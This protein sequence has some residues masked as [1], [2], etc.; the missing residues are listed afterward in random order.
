MQCPFLIFSVRRDFMDYKIIGGSLPVAVCKLRRGEDVLC[1]SGAMSW[2]DG[3]IRMETEGGGLG[4]MFGRAFS[5]ESMFIN[6]YIAERDGEIAFASKFPGDIRAIELSRGKSIIAQK[7]CL[8][9]YDSSVDVNVHFHKRFS[10]GFFGGEGFI[11]Q[12]FSG[13]GTVLIEIDGSAVEYELDEGERKIINTGYL[14]MMD[15]TCSMSVETVRGVKNVLFGGESLFNTVITG[16]GKIVLQTMPLAQTA[17][18]LY[19]MMPHNN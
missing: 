14:V 19:S 6:R 11:M 7:K 8:L 5:G 2:M 13:E 10:A 1:E 4:R 12:K 17:A 3:G 9:A 16:P 15:E 18:L